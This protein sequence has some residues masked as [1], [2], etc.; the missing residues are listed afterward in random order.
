MVDFLQ[1]YEVFLPTKYD[2]NNV[3]KDAQCSET[4]FLCF[5]VFYFFN[6]MDKMFFDE[7]ISKVVM[8][9]WKMR[10]VETN[11]KSVSDF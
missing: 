5:W 1:I 10:N 9:T 6:Q 4:D 3:S 8:I 2:K 7:K 11:E